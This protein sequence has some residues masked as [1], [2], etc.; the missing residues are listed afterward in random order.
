MRNEANRKARGARATRKCETKP[1]RGGGG[2]GEN[3]WGRCAKRSQSGGVWG[4]GNQ[5][6]KRS[7]SAGGRPHACTIAG[8][9]FT[10]AWARCA[11]RSQSHFR[12]VGQSGNP[13]YFQ[14]KTGIERPERMCMNRL[15]EIAVMMAGIQATSR[16][17]R[18]LP[19]MSGIGE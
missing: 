14:Y 19:S 4:E 10:N 17:S 9:A 18:R 6:A 12:T 2:H 3:A 1:I 5:D 11:K 16:I 8:E 13:F 15:A 7:Q